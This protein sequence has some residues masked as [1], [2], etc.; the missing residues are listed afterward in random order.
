MAVLSAD[1]YPPS[2]PKLRA[3]RNSTWPRNSST[4]T[5]RKGA[6]RFLRARSRRC[7]QFCPHSSVP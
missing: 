3:K 2:R 1:T 4:D 5:L 7:R 6:G